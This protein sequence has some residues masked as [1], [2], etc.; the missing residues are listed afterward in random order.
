MKGNITE[1]E[2]KYLLENFK[3][4][5]DALSSDNIR[6]INQH[7]DPNNEKSHLPLSTRLLAPSV[8]TIVN[9][10]DKKTSR[11]SVQKMVDVYNSLFMPPT[12]VDSFLTTN[13]FETDHPRKINHEISGFFN[14][15]YYCFYFSDN[16]QDEIHGGILR[17]F[18]YAGG[19]QCYLI[20]GLFNEVQFSKISNEVFGNI[21]DISNISV[22]RERFNG[23]RDKQP[24]RPEFKNFSLSVGTIQVLDR[25]ILVEVRN[26]NNPNHITIATV[27]TA[28]NRNLQQFSGG[29]GVYLSP[30][31][32]DLHTR[33]CKMLILRKADVSEALLNRI[34]ENPEDSFWFRSMKITATEYGRMEILDE[35]INKKIQSEISKLNRP[36]YP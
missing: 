23:Y 27:G 25:S 7:F 4:M 11:A 14:G 30:A 9:F 18:E 29:M 35:D 15:E 3:L 33:V 34:M 31:T 28:H 12:N 6:C 5:K 8:R 19:Y 16:Y 2:R 26:I 1:E 24:D 36:F 17:V 10:N 20:M 22:V 13:V 21:T 32:D